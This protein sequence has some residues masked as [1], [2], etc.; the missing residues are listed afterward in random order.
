MKEVKLKRY[1]GPFHKVPFKNFVQSPI[2]LV[3]KAGNKTRLIFHLSYDFG[4]S[5]MKSINH[6]TLKEKCSVKYHDLDEAVQKCL[7][8]RNKEELS[9]RESQ[10]SDQG[11]RTFK[12]IFTGKTDLS[13]AFHMIPLQPDCYQWLIMKVTNPR[14]ETV[15]FVDKCL[16]FGDSISCSHFQRFSEALRH[17][18]EHRLQKWDCIVNYLDDFL[19]IAASKEECDHMIQEFT[20]LCNELGVP[21]AAEKTEWGSTRT[22]FLGILIDGKHYVLAVPEEKRVKAIKML[23]YIIEKWKVNVK[24]IERLAGYLNF[25]TRAIFPGRVFTRRMYSKINYNIERNNLKSF[26]HVKVDAEFK[27]D[28]RTWLD[29]L[30]QPCMEKMVCRPWVDLTG[31]KNAEEINFYSDASRS[32]TE[33]GL[34]AVLNN[35]WLIGK[36]PEEFMQWDPSIE[37]LELFALLAAVL[38]WAPLLSNSHY[39]IFCDNQSVVQMVNQTTS[40]CKNCMVLLR[41]IVREQLKHNFRIFT[42]HVRT[43]NNQLSD[44]L[45]RGQL[46]HFRREAQKKG[47]LMAEF[48]EE[49]PEEIWPPTKI[50]LAQ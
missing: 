41:K 46:T 44:A 28:C 6:Y 24:E 13:S 19:F 30:T 22:V 47:L 29:F 40:S 17:I 33:G 20:K 15:Y 38:R 50:W 32:K 11:Q 9:L 21:I 26:H 18:L 25:L 39:T 34:G 42:K 7:A 23:E 35:K 37:Y 5:G 14:G 8:L 1:A 45:S 4:K 12:E 48:P 16:P 27:E 36:W 49:I 3:P 43:E 10:S 31:T 2:G